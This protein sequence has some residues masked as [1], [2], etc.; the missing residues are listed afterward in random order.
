MSLFEKASRL[1]I[2]F[3]TAQGTLSTDDLWDLPLTSE[4]KV[5]L[6]YIAKG[7]Y[8][9]IKESEVESFVVTETKINESL[10]VAFDIVKHVISVRMAEAKTIETAKEKKERKQKILALIEQKQ[11][12]ELSAKSL[13]ELREMVNAED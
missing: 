11:D 13:E 6:D 9:K 4:R 1:K 10:Q 7:L 2:R 5:S 8:R 12:A 3:D